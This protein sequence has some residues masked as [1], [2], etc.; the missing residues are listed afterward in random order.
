MQDTATKGRANTVLRRQQEVSCECTIQRNRVSTWGTRGTTLLYVHVRCAP[1][2]VPYR[3]PPPPPPNITHQNP[4]VYMPVYALRA[5]RYC[6][7]ILSY[8]YIYIRHRGI[9]YIKKTEG[10][11]SINLPTI[12]NSFHATSCGRGK[13]V[14]KRLVGGGGTLLL[15][16]S[17]III[18]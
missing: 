14:S 10:M 8:T 9:V 4:L 16:D 18:G 13:I 2:V 6:T 3:P 12:H 17:N 11:Y 5:P 1:V 7:N 15:D